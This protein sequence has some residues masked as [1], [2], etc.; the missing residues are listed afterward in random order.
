[1]CVKFRAVAA[2][3]AILS[4]TSPLFAAPPRP[5]RPADPL[6][7]LLQSEEP[8]SRADALTLLKD[9]GGSPCAALGAYA[10]DPRSRVRE[11]AVRVMGDAGCADFES[12]RGFVLDR[13]AGVADALI[14]AARRGLMA[15]AVPFLLGSLS[16]R[17]RLVTQAGSWSIAER[18]QRALMIITCQSFHY[19]VA[20]TRDDQR[21][22]IARWRQWYLS[23]RGLPREEWVQEG[24]ERARDYA[25]R[26]HAPHRLEGLRLLALIGA[27]ALPALRERLV[28]R[29]GDLRTDVICQPDEAPRPGDSVPCALVVQNATK[30]PVPLAPSLEGPQIRLSPVDGP[31]EEGSPARPPSPSDLAQTLGLFADRLTELA[32]GE[33]RRFEF[34]AGPVLLSG[35]YR[36]RAALLDWAAVL[37]SS[38]QDG[39]APKTAGPRAPAASPSTIEAE[40]ILRFER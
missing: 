14:D 31:R 37:A 15:D 2:F 18:A 8:R 30:R 13:S 29:P 11:N 7:P 36:V 22:A 24:I 23:R 26:D 6:L 33:L 32:P 5:D 25:G 27:P 21:D 10:S 17:R 39:A 40:T 38:G 20:S 4:S 12:Y 1:M 3:A 16:D 35:R 9:L 28:R 34:I 19:D